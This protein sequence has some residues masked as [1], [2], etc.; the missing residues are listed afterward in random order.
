[1]PSD[2]LVT[3]HTL[4]GDI[5]HGLVAI[6]M[7]ILPLLEK[8]VVPLV[9]VGGTLGGVYWA[10]KG[11][12]QI[13]EME[14]MHQTK[15]ENTREKRNILYLIFND[16]YKTEKYY[17]QINN[18]FRMIYHNKQLSDIYK[19]YNSYYNICINSELYFP[20]IYKYF[21]NEFKPKSEAYLNLI[22]SLKENQLTEDNFNK[23]NTYFDD[24]STEI[25]NFKKV[26]KKEAN[27]LMN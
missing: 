17:L 7:M 12:R 3:I 16:C 18:A 26:I 13:K 21:K 23:M 4:L 14:L 19:E 1:M 24:L 27:N 6:L 22:F 2:T 5:Y 11:Q 25:E 10:Q 8:A 20:E 15:T 9:T